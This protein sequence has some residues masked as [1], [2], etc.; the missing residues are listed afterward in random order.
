MLDKPQ[1]TNWL[2]NAIDLDIHIGSMNDEVKYATEFLFKE[3]SILVTVERA[4]ARSKEAL[5]LILLNLWISAHL[6]M[7]V[8]YSR[9]RNDYRHHKR[10]GKLHFKHKRIISIID[11]LEELSYIENI[12]GFYDRE[13]NLGRQSRMYATKKLIDLFCHN[14]LTEPGFITKQEPEEIIQL[15]DDDKILKGYP[16]TDSTISMKSGLI[17]YNNFIR[18]QDIRINLNRNTEVN[19]RFLNQLYHNTLKG[20]INPSNLKLSYNIIED[21]SHSLNSNYDN[22]ISDTRIIEQVVTS[23]PYSNV[24]YS[25]SPTMT[26][27]L[28]EYGSHPYDNEIIIEY[29]NNIAIQFFHIYFPTMTKTLRIIE[30]SRKGTDSEQEKNYLGDIGIEHLIFKLNYESLHRVFN[31]NS[32][33]YGGRFY[34]AYHLGLPKAIRSE[35]QIN[36]QPTV[37]LDYSSL[38]IRM[39]YHMEGIDY[40]QD[41][42]GILSETKEERKM[43]KLVQLISINAENEKKAVMAI[44]DAFR[45]KKIQYPLNND[46][47]HKLLDKFKKVHWQIAKYLHSG[48]GLKLQNKDSIITEDILISLMN[49]NIPCL[50]VHDSY[51]VPEEYEDRLYDKMI[52]AYEKVMGFEPVIG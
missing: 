2:E 6:D 23:Y 8:K 35:I 38:H 29:S 51:I 18:N 47:I 45:K 32:F 13:K 17:D 39:L 44:R 26:K 4:K 12:K 27:T 5:K 40:R 11:A 50:P 42:Y 24:P 19:V 52:E 43:Y 37:E 41:P 1:N 21:S 49:E 10:Y 7:P 20:V 30:D 15:K 16:D 14:N 25:Y 46:A 28:R 22:R 34:G 33:E 3:L 48:Q 9:N 31:K 36:G